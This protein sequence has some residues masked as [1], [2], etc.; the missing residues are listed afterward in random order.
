L[1]PTCR[2]CVSSK[3]LVFTVELRPSLAGIERPLTSL[4]DVRYLN[5]ASGDFGQLRNLSS[6]LLVRSR[7]LQSEQVSQ[8]IYSRVYLGSFL[9]LGPVVAR[10]LT[11]LGRRL[12]CAAV[13]DR[14]GRLGARAR[15]ETERS[16]A[17]CVLC[18]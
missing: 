13:E 10:A 8:G 15:R 3:W 5:S 12:D 7:D 9:L 17:D 18:P 4:I 14:G 11:A 1:E 16:L 6:F 2:I